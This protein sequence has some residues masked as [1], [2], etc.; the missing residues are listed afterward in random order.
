MRLSQKNSHLGRP[1]VVRRVSRTVQRIGVSEWL[2][3]AVEL[4]SEPVLKVHSRSRCGVH[5]IPLAFPPLG[6]PVFEPYLCIIE[7]F[8]NK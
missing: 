1:I 5:C 2:H 8:F 6:P 3:E 4:C 7:Y